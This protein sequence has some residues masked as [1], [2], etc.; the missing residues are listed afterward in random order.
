M[1]AD[2]VKLY[3]VIS[4]EFSCDKLQISLHNIYSWSNHWQLKLSPS[5]CTALHLKSRRSCHQDPLCD[6]RYSIGDSSL[7]VCSTV[8]DLGMCYD[9]CKKLS[10]L[11]MV[12]EAKS[13][14]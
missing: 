8:I 3:T 5:K 7:P 14:V 9:K 12:L 6:D 13:H 10:S 1:F 11:N 4:D 2:D